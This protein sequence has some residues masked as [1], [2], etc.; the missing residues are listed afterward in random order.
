LTFQTGKLFETKAKFD[1]SRDRGDPLQ[2]VLGR[3]QV[4]RGWDEGLLGMVKGEKRVLTIPPQKAYGP[5][6][7]LY[8]YT[9]PVYAD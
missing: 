6:S 1:S 7:V 4:I 5:Y 8:L 9:S 2:F 3:G